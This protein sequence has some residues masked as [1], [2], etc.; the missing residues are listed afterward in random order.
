MPD[1]LGDSSSGSYTRTAK[2]LAQSGGQ[3]KA[4][5]KPS[6]ADG[7]F[8]LSEAEL[9]ARGRKS[10]TVKPPALKKGDSNVVYIQGTAAAVPFAGLESFWRAFWS[11]VAAALRVDR[12]ALRFAPAAQ[13][14]DDQLMASAHLWL[15]EQVLESLA[16]PES[17]SRVELGLRMLCDPSLWQEDRLDARYGGHP[18]QEMLEAVRAARDEISAQKLPCAVDVEF[19][20]INKLITIGPELAPCRPPLVTVK[21]ECVIGRSVGFLMNDVHL[22]HFARKFGNASETFVF[23]PTDEMRDQVRDVSRKYAPL[24]E[25]ELEVVRHGDVVVTSTIQRIGVVNESL[26]LD[27]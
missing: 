23:K 17:W 21:T 4:L 25:V 20:R 13:L 1:L 14:Q 24:I 11:I 10:A 19:S 12:A 9:H 15:G 2:S 3:S 5:A 6:T 22:M 18:W 8:D 26:F 16:T 27:V 7:Q